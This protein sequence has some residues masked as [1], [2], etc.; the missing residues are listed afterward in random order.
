LALELFET[1]ESGAGVLNA[2]LGAG[3][4]VGGAVT[5]G[6]ASRRRLGPALVL[7]AIVAGSCVL[8]IAFVP[9]PLAAPLLIAT[10]GLGLSLLDAT[11]R[12]MLQRSVREQTLAGAFGVL[13]GLSMAGLGLGSILVPILVAVLGLQQTVFVVGAILPVLGV[14]AIPGLHRLDATSVVPERELA[15]LGRVEMFAPL[16][17]QVLESLAHRSSWLSLPAGTELIREGDVGDRY[18]VLGSGSLAA[19]RA[20]EHL[21]TLTEPGEGVGEIALLFDVPR[22]ATVRTI[23]DAELLILERADFL[24][25]VTGHPEVHRAAARVADERMAGR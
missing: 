3:G 25:A 11:G 4:V 24:T 14:L 16:R 2:A 19:E 15:L 12:T 21:R 17:P 22:T 23:D 18:Y 20:G 9:S 10:S 5:L 6:V 13:E 8:V 7:G 1:G